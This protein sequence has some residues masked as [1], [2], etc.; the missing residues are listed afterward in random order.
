MVGMPSFVGKVISFSQGRAPKIFG[1]ARSEQSEFSMRSLALRPSFVF[2]TLTKRIRRTR[3]E[4]I[5]SLNADDVPTWSVEDSSRVIADDLTR[6]LSRRNTQQANAARAYLPRI[7]QRVEVLQLLDTTVIHQ[8]YGCVVFS[9]ASGFTALTE[10]LAQKP[11]GAEVLSKCLNKFFTPLIDIIDAYRGD[12]IKFSGDALTILFEATDDYELHPSPCGS[13]DMPRKTAEELACLRASACCLEIHKRLHNFETGEGGVRLTLHIGVGAGDITILQVGGMHGRYEYVIAGSPMEQTAVAEP[14]AGSGETVLSPQAWEKVQHTVVAGVPLTEGPPGFRRLKA[15]DTTKHTYPT[16]K[17]AARECAKRQGLVCPEFGEGAIV[18]LSERFIPRAIMR[19]LRSGNNSSINEMRSVTI[20]FAS[21][22]GVDVS[23]HAGSGVAQ[24]LMMQL[25]AAC[26][27][28]EGNLNKFIVDDKGI[29]FLFVFGLSPLVHI[30][31]P[32]RAISSCFEMIDS[33]KRMGLRGRFGVTTGRVFCGVVGSEGRREY[34]VMGDT[35]NLSARLMAKAAENT[36]LIDEAT[37]LRSRDEV[38]CERLEPFLVKGKANKIQCFKPHVPAVHGLEI[39]QLM[40][41]LGQR[42]WNLERTDFQVKGGCS[43]GPATL[44]WRAS[45]EAMGGSSPMLRLTRWRE[46]QKLDKM[47]LGPQNDNLLKLGGSILITGPSGSGK[48]ELGERLISLAV[49]EAGLEPLFGV[50]RARKTE[51]WRPAAQLIQNCLRVIWLDSGGQ[52][53]LQDAAETILMKVVQGNVFQQKVLNFLG[54][55]GFSVST[56]RARR[57][58]TM[59]DSEELQQGVAEIIGLLVQEVANARGVLV[60]LRVRRGTDI[61]DALG[62]AASGFWR[63]AAHLHELATRRQ[64]LIRLGA[65][66]KPI[67]VAV[68]ARTGPDPGLDGTSIIKLDR[69][70]ARDHEIRMCPL[71]EDAA[72]ELMCHC[73]GLPT[74]NGGSLVKR[75]LREFT[76]AV[77]IKMPA[78]IQ[79]C[80]RHLRKDACVEVLDGECDIKEELNA[81]NIAEWVETSMVGST[82]SQLESLGSAKNHIMKLATVFEGPF[83]P[84]DL[85]AAN[86]VLFGRLP[87]ILAF[88]NQAKLLTACKELQEAGFLRSV[89]VSSHTTP[90]DKA[91]VRL[92][93]WTIAN[94]L[95]RKVAGSMLLNSQRILIK[96]AVLIERALNVELPHRIRAGGLGGRNKVL[97]AQLGKGGTTGD[98]D[99]PPPL[100]DSPPQDDAEARDILLAACA[101]GS[102]AVAR[103]VLAGPHAPDLNTTV[104]AGGYTPLHFACSSGEVELIHLLCE[105][106]AKVDT[107]SLRGETPMLVA[108]QR[109]HLSAVQYLFTHRGSLNSQEVDP[110]YWDRALPDITTEEDIPKPLTPCYQANDAGSSELLEKKRKEVYKW[111]LEKVSKVDQN[112]SNNRNSAKHLSRSEERLRDVRIGIKEKERK[113]SLPKARTSLRSSTN[114]KTE[115]PLDSPTHRRLSVTSPVGDR[116]SVSAREV[117][118]ALPAFLRNAA[119][120]ARARAVLRSH[121]VVVVMLVALALALYMPDFWVSVGSPSNTG[122]DVVL[123]LVMMLFL[124]EL[125][126]LAVVD[127]SYSCSFFFWMDLIGTVSMVWDIP[128]MAG[129]SATQVQTAQGAGSDLTLFRAARSAKIAARAG[130]L[131]RLVKVMR[132]LPGIGVSRGRAG[133]D[134][135]KLQQISNQLTNVLSKRLACLTVL[136]VVVMPLFTLGVY[137]ELDLSMQVWVEALSRRLNDLQGMTPD[138]QGYLDKFAM[139]YE[140]QSYGPFRVCIQKEGFDAGC[141]DLRRSSFSPPERKS[142]QLDVQASD[143]VASYD[144]SGPM[145]SEANAGIVLMSLVIVL[146]CGACLLLNYSASELAVRPLERM[147]TSIKASAK[148]IFSSVRVLEV[149]QNEEFGEDMDGEVALLERVVEKIAMLAE[150]SS[151]KSPFDEATMT[152]MKNEELGVL[153]LTSPH[154]LRRRTESTQEKDDDEGDEHQHTGGVTVTMKWQLEEIGMRYEIVNSWSFNVLSL[155]APKVEQVAVWLLMNNPGSCAHTEQHVGIPMLRA[156]VGHVSKGYLANPYHN[157]LHAVDVVHAVFRYLA[158]M[159]AEHLFSMLEQFAMLVASVS[160]DVGHIGLNNGFLTEVQHDLAIRYN[161]RSPLENMHCCKLFEILAQAE[162]NVFASVSPEQYRDVRK[163]IIDVIL[164]TDI[165]QHNAMVKEL[166]LLFEMNSKVFAARNGEHMAEQEMEVLS[167]AE[168]KKLVGRLVLHAADTSNPTKPW[169]IAKA[170]AYRVLDE[171]AAQGDQEKKLGIPVQMLNDRNKVNRPNS[172]IGFIEFILTPLVAVEVKIFPAWGKASET[173]EENLR[174]WEALWI[175]EST[176]TEAEKEKVSERVRKISAKLKPGTGVE[177]LQSNATKDTKSRRRPSSDRT[178]YGVRQ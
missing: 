1:H 14:L 144:Y 72:V 98:S 145:K 156:F 76:I 130:R 9:D 92:P 162:V 90:A 89:I 170:W 85:A 108:A 51:Q 133:N 42:S 68:V 109:G 32:V 29:V 8:C 69:R 141:Y 117:L 3:T 96:R 174:L 19:H 148:A 33:L 97:E 88:Y 110:E 16:V 128:C 115:G 34:T 173:L 139:F 177:D 168:N 172:Q 104:E 150:L 165:V 80:L 166:E 63:L 45:S 112:S 140:K 102:T 169:D 155:D 99:A 123:T 101:L 106:N 26:Y 153:A 60:F 157:F 160:H 164:H 124:F 171:Y 5:P 152:D 77:S 56:E 142:F 62:P 126:L 132:F 54:F 79:E 46:L 70:P 28:Y 146:M 57:I 83:S 87:R 91:P 84:I 17:K 50:A 113:M 25:Q 138:F 121:T 163:S 73:L 120:R 75:K 66:H 111:V 125:S 41:V 100:F 147:L 11:D 158:L 52:G 65:S 67:L 37:Y 131:S 135:E 137:P 4:E 47:L 82:I 10:T 58:E 127:A 122:I 134:K 39:G 154:R 149:E 71:T 43:V 36:V 59:L 53:T 93:R 136:L 48:Q 20:I 49:G 105:R 31:D 119:F 103:Q 159:Q 22:N 24:E 107:R 61:Y 175:E 94:S 7:L 40:P 81:V 129:E 176:P 15:L 64:R 167:N 35:V 55:E 18:R 12:V 23:T 143:I 118:P 27:S 38:T 74:T 30:D 13:P 6:W 151:K 78:Y 2:A 116:L 86:R 21:I 114:M 95:F 161:D 178:R 44:P